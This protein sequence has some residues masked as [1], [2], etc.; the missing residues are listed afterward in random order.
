MRLADLRTRW[1]KVAPQS[2]GSAGVGVDLE[3][4][5][6]RWFPRPRDSR[7]SLPLEAE[8]MRSARGSARRQVRTRATGWMECA[9]PSA[10]GARLLPHDRHRKFAGAGPSELSDRPQSSARSRKALSSL[11][12]ITMAISKPRPPTPCRTTFTCGLA[13]LAVRWR[14]E[15]ET[16]EQRVS[17]PRGKESKLSRC[18][19]LGNPRTL[20]E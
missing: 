17:T 15:K 9:D 19:H 14:D 11:T 3:E 7:S 2:A 20:S 13:S 12:E 10:T 16:K 4:S 18:L 6:K 5:G 1:P 8:R